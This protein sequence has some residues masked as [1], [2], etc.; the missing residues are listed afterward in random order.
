MGAGF[1][2]LYTR[3][4]YDWTERFG[5]LATSTTRVGPTMGCCRTTSAWSRR[6]PRLL[7]LRS[8]PRGWLGSAARTAQGAAQDAAGASRGGSKRIRFSEHIEGEGEAVVKQACAMGL[9]GIIS[10]DADSPYRSGRAG[11]GS[12]R[13]S[14]DARTLSRSLPSS[15]NSGQ[16]RAGLLRSISVAMTMGGSATPARRA[17]ATHLNQR[18][19]FVNCSIRIFAQRHLSTTRSTSPRPRGSSR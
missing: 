4:G 10:K 2:L 16:S 17:A 6:A 13:R 5:P 12:K 3:R 11:D 7:R 1:A 19:I 18:N 9:E 15:K 8:S 14:A